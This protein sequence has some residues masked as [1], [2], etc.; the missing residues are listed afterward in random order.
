MPFT[1]GHIVSEETKQ[2][3]RKPK[4]EAHITAIQESKLRKKLAKLL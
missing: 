2:K 1:K 4:S 3:M